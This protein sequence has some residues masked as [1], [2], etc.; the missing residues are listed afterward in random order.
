MNKDSP[1]LWQ[2]VNETQKRNDP[3][4]NLYVMDVVLNSYTMYTKSTQNII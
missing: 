3:T 1:L 4:R 2:S